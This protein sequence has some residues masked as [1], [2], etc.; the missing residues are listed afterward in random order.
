MSKNKI[1]IQIESEV[2]RTWKAF[3]CA[4]P[5]K[6]KL[7][8]YEHLEE[9]PNVFYTGDILNLLGLPEREYSQFKGVRSENVTRNF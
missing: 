2:G 3:I 5:R 4:Y 7:E 9:V 1:K 8:N 6:S